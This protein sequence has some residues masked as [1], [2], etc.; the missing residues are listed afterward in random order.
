MGKLVEEG[1]HEA[2]EAMASCEADNR[3][4]LGVE[5]R[6]AIEFAA[7][8]LRFGDEDDPAGGKSGLD[9]Y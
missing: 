5:Q 7:G 2:I 1:E 4:S 8:K 6:D 9:G 3:P